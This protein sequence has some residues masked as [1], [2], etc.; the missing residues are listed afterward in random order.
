MS[1]K[2]EVKQTEI[3]T[4]SVEEMQELEDE[5]LNETAGGTGDTNSPNYG[6][7]I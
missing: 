6:C 7:Q 1:E 5:I 2:N 4:L 3:E